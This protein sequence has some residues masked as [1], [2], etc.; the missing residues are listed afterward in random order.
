MMKEIGVLM[1]FPM[2]PHLEQQLDNRFNLFRLW[3][4]PDKNQFFNDIRAAAVNTNV[5]ADRQLIDS[6]PALEIV[7]S[8]SVGL[9][10]VDLE[11][12]KKKGIRVTNTPDVLTDDVADVAIGL[13]IATLRRICECDRFTKAGLWNKR[14]F[15]LTTK[16]GFHF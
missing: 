11:Y 9:D 2:N 16:V 10:K 8:C 1:T 3:N 14:D 13:I 12:C 7:S 5:G 15:K 4:I 6:L